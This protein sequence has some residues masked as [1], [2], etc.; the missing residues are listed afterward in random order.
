MVID[1]DIK[2][3]IKVLE[4]KAEKKKPTPF[5]N[6]KHHLFLISAT[7]GGSVHI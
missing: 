6:R 1:F 3:S 4:D 5:S 2:N 7:R